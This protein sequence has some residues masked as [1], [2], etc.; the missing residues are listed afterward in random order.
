MIPA[1]S[2]LLLAACRVGTASKTMPM[3]PEVRRTALKRDGGWP[4]GRYPSQHWL[5]QDRRVAGRQRPNWD[6]GELSNCSPAVPHC[7]DK[8]RER[9]LPNIY[10][11]L[12]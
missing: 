10:L 2:E 7:Y 6:S 9:E 4:D 1:A 3:T 11:A 8:D 5:K 12:Q